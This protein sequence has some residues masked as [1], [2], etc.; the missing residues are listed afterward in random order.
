MK[1]QLIS[2]YSLLFA[3]TCIT[4]CKKASDAVVSADGSS[5]GQKEKIKDEGRVIDDLSRQL[6][7]KY[8][9]VELTQEQ[10]GQTEFP[11]FSDIESASAFIDQ[12]Q[13]ELQQ[14]Y[15]GSASTQSGSYPPVMVSKFADPPFQG[16]CRSP[17]TYFANMPGSGGLFSSFRAALIF[18]GAGI[19][20]GSIYVTGVP[21][22]WTWNQI[23]T[24]FNGSSTRGCVYGTITYGIKTN[25]LTLALIVPYHFNLNFSPDGC[26]L[27]YSQGNGG[28]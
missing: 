12:A 25:S 13:R 5:V 26:M 23:G 9:M 27:Y 1:Y 20:G 22:G 11:T 7:N 3:F 21:I 10:I 16:G 15:G 2:F 6:M 14:S 28:C 8:G 19:A 17:A 18:N 24:T 4:G